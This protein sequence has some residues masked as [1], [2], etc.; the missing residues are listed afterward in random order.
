MKKVSVNRNPGNGKEKENLNLKKAL[1]ASEIRYR[2]LFESAKDGI[3][4][5][6]AE[7]GM[8]VDVN[9]FLIDLLGYSKD[10]FIH[11]A[12]W[13]IGFLKDIFANKEKFLELQQAEYVRYEDLPLETVDGRKIHVEFVSNVYMA[14]NQK[15]IQCNIRDITVRKSYE[16]SIL[17]LQKAVD[18]SGEII[19]LTDK[20][21]V[22]TFINPAFTIIYGFTAGEIINKVTPR[23]L[24]SG[25]MDENDYKLFWET[26]ISGKEVRIEFIN[27]RKDGTVINIEGSASPVFNDKTEIIGF[28]GIQR[29]I[30]RRKHDEEEIIMLAQSLKS[31]HECVSIT[32]MKDNI[33]FVN[34]SFLNTYGYQKNELIG[35][36]I[37]IVRSDNNSSKLVGKI[38]PHTISGRWHGELWNKRKDGSEFLIYLSTTIINDN[39]GNSLGLIGVASDITVRKRTEKE[40]VN[41]RLKA[42]ESDRLK[43]AFLANMSHEIR[44]PMNGILGFTELLKT[45]KLTG[46]EQQN[47]IGIIEKSGARMLN[48]INDIIN[49]SKIESGQIEISVSNI[50][51]NEQLADIYNFFKP[52]A[53]HKNLNISFKNGLP[54]NK[55]F[56]KTDK[57]KLYAIL[58]NLVKNALK[59]TKSGSIE[60]GYKVN[61]D[62][63]EFYI[64]D[65]GPGIFH[66]Q[67]AYIFERFRQGSESLTRNYEGAGL[68]LAISKAYVEVLGGTI[69][70]ESEI[71]KGSTFYFTIPYV[72]PFEEKIQLNTVAGEEIQKNGKLKIVVAEDDEISRILLNIMIENLADEIFHAVNSI[73][74]VE[75]CRNNPD[76]DLVLMDINMSGMDGYEATR[77]IRMFNK[78]VIIIAQTAY[79]LSIDRE[80]ALAA[81]C[82]D[83]ISKPVSRKALQ[84]MINKYFN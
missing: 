10:N 78:E 12:I 60:F 40:L 74:A 45:P 67:R 46:K 20:E 73:E 48:I 11:K 9:P 28:L 61:G 21:G 82:N 70:V 80:K 81:G 47:Y 55:A 66:E 16:A 19:F 50:N 34:E 24:K 63:F 58:T 17:K 83:Y 39:Q 13:E 68:G 27:K 43:S 62:F 1:I 37:S 30:T 36:N 49:I 4:I 31:V 14:E 41:A 8:I 54:T 5:L 26:L 64:K 72:C 84:L 18:S 38:L 23:I 7:T 59:F 65:S 79:A 6:D 44:T 25:L 42:E 76:I 77:Q 71:E 33:L 52:E 29:D 2:R 32:D 53:I 22:F 35:K 51:I 75:A 15:V 57:E 3:L 69:W 56:I